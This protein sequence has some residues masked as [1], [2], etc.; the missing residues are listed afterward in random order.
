[1]KFWSFSDRPQKPVGN[2]KIPIPQ[3]VKIKLPKLKIPTAKI[4]NIR[5]RIKHPH[6]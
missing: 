4:Q 2:G 3:A 6:A 5:I 1:M